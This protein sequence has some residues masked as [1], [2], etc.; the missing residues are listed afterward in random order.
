LKIEAMNGALTP[1]QLQSQQDW[2][3]WTLAHEKSRAWQ[4][5]ELAR[6]QVSGA[7]HSKSLAQSQAM[8]LAR[9]QNQAYGISPPLPAA[10]W[11]GKPLPDLTE[12]TIEL[13]ATSL[14]LIAEKIGSAPEGDQDLFYGLKM[15]LALSGFPVDAL[16]VKA[17]A[18]DEVMSVFCA[19]VV[20]LK[21]RLS[22]ESAASRIIALEKKGPTALWWREE[23]ADNTVDNLLTFTARGFAEQQGYLRLPVDQSRS[24]PAPVPVSP[25]PVPVSPAPVPT[26]PDQSRLVPVWSRS[27]PA[28]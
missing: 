16:D 1:E 2:R 19:R 22:E 6:K 27:G 9:R 20:A 7:A 12:E 21:T 25:A 11:P 13:V 5:M 23:M 28:E 4:S 10:G 3:D 18:R 14:Q 26:G 8:D 15:V 24:G 17:F